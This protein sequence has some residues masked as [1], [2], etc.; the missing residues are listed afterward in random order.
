[1]R[2]APILSSLLMLL[3]L[4]CKSSAEQA[5]PPAPPAAKAP[6]AAKPPPPAGP[7]AADAKAFAAR[8]NADLE[9]LWSDWERAEWIKATYITHDTELM[10][11]A[12]HEKAL[13]YTSRAIKEATRFDGLA[14]DPD[15]ARTIALLKVSQSMPAPNDPAKRKRLA[16]ISAQMES[17]YG[18]G[19]FCDGK[20]SCKDLGEL[21][22]ILAESHD[23]DALLRAW[24]GWRTISPEMRPMYGEF[25]A[26]A[27][28][29]AKEI[30]FDNLGELW[31]AAYDMTPAEFEAET[32]R[33]WTQVKPLYDQL[34]CYVRGRL[35]EKYGKDKV[36]PKGLIPAH[37]LGNMWA[38]EWANVYPLV[39]PYKGELLHLARHGSAP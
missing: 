34:H 20:G 22:K 3:P 35:A 24:T 16:E 31:R 29:G 39:E 8:V 7:T 5:P 37:L 2:S 26:I 9:Q 15:T 36:D 21:S 1:M 6:E 33:L 12:F 19:K 18:K 23:Y 14:L 11:A 25:V 38:Q 13:E 10:A 17:V 27:N 30:G 32:D 28:E 4:A